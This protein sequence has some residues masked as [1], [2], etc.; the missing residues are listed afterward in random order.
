MRGVS[1]PEK[2]S[3]D[4]EENYFI[5]PVKDKNPFFHLFFT[6]VL[7]LKVSC[8]C[9]SFAD[10]LDALGAITREGWKGS[11]LLS[12]NLTPKILIWSLSS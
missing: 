7:N 12:P 2:A 3:E 1:E 5:L 8:L 11:S 6:W 10:A 9:Q 4:R